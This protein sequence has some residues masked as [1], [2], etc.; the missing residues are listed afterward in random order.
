MPL[1]H[2]STGRVDAIVQ[3]TDK[4]FMVPVGGAVVAASKQLPDL[5][6]AVNKLY[7]GRAAVNAHLDLLMTLLSW[8]VQGWTQV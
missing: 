3:S 2:P 5:V 7:P 4:N 8:G 1:A 6:H